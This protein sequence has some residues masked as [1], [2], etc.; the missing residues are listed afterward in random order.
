ML[1]KYFLQVSIHKVSWHKIKRDNN[2]ASPSL[3]LLNCHLCYSYHML[4]Q[5]ISYKIT[6]CHFLHIIFFFFLAR[7]LLVKTLFSMILQIQFQ[8]VYI[9]VA[10]SPDIWLLFG[11]RLNQTLNVLFYRHF[12]KIFWEIFQTFNYLHQ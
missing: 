8:L 9:Y 1:K 4:R 6:Q 3:H 7:Q 2:L 10:F 11:Q 5:K 12:F